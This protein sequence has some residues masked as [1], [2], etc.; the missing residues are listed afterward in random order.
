M[1]HL[2]YI[3]HILKY[4]NW[5]KS[6]DHGSVDKF[7]L[8]FT[9]SVMIQISRH[10]PISALTKTNCQRM[11]PHPKVE[12][13][14]IKSFDVSQSCYRK[15]LSSKI[16]RIFYFFIF[17]LTVWERIQ[18]Y[19]K[20]QDIE[21]WRRLEQVMSNHLLWAIKPTQNIWQVVTLIVNG[22]NMNRIVAT[23]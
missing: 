7:Y 9:S 2:G 4:N 6:S 5:S 8:H 11:P 17:V 16:F 13:F 10:S 3:K 15:L 18:S 19:K 14:P 22:K 12:S 23:S 21:L 20:C 1:L